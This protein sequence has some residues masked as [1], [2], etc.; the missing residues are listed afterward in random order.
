M[1]DDKTRAMGLGEEDH[2]GKVPFSSHHI[3]YLMSIPLITAA[4]NLA[5]QA[6]VM[7]VTTVATRKL[8][9]PPFHTVLFRTISLCSAHS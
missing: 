8:H 7:S 6:E 3:E 9:F 1:P 5:Q 2:G 4:V